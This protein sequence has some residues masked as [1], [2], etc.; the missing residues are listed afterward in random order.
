MSE[1]TTFNALI[2]RRAHDLLSAQGWPEHTEVVLSSPTWPGW[3]DVCVRMSEVDMIALL[4]RLCIT[5]DL[6]LLQRNTLHV[7]L[8]KLTGTKIETVLYRGGNTLWPAVPGDSTEVSFL[9]ATQWLT[10][11]EIN[12]LRELVKSSV[13]KVC[14]QVVDDT[15]CI[16]AAVTPLSDPRL[17]ERRTR[18][19]RV[20]AEECDDENWLAE[21][22]PE[23][24]RRVLAAILN[25]GARYG[26]VRLT[27]A[28]DV[29]DSIVGYSVMT[30]VLR[31]PGEPPRRWLDRDVVHEALAFARQDVISIL[32]AH[33]TFGRKG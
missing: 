5:S 29:M 2:C 3:L 28:S 15:R 23:D 31:H 16:Q 24:V 12:L 30:D 6:S 25:E 33:R 11:S 8:K 9:F 22:A 18:Y 14:I 10:E 21:S 26:A 27:V 13:R 4:Q 17:F 32:N 1:N 20:I 7:A 19:F